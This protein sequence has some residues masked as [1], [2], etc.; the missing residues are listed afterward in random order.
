MPS[1]VKEIRPTPRHVIIRSNHLPDRK[2]KKKKKSS[3]TKKQ[4]P[5]TLRLF[6]TEGAK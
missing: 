3:H 1:K 6:P 4:N 5:N 2:E